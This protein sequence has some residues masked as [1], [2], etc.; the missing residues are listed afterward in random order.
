MRDKK[1]AIALVLLALPTLFVVWLV[2]EAILA[3]F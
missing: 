1:L 2:A 3:G